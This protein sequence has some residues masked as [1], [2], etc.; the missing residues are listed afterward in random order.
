MNVRKDRK[1]LE[2]AIKRGIKTAAEL[3][4]YLRLRE[5]N[6]AGNLEAG[7]SRRWTLCRTF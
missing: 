1:I 6:S 7:L 3:A 5:E 4:A 2:E